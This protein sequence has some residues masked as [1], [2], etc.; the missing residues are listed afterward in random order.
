MS[1]KNIIIK[2]FQIEKDSQLSII[3]SEKNIYDLICKEGNVITEI[4]TCE[5]VKVG[6]NYLEVG[7]K[8]KIKFE[9]LNSN[10]F[11][12]KKI[13]IKTKYNFNSESSDEIEF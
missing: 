3:D 13:Y 6:I 2:S 4:V 7:D 1:K 11:I 8:I 9:T 10:K 12:I 5:N